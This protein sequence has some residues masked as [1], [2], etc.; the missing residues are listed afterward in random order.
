[1]YVY[2]CVCV[3]VCVYVCMC[4]CVR[5]YVCVCMCVCMC[6]CVCVCVHLS[7]NPISALSFKILFQSTEQRALRR[8]PRA[9]STA[10]QLTRAPPRLLSPLVYANAT[11]ACDCVGG[12]GYAPK[13]ILQRG[14]EETRCA[15]CIITI[16]LLQKIVCL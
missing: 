1:M 5:M 8:I 6:V 9:L 7:Y 3:C 16:S 12:R 11:K 4:V 10:L 2:V 14:S 13:N 15:K